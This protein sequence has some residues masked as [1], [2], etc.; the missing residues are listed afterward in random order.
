[1][2]LQH[3]KLDLQSAMEYLMTYGWALLIIAVVLAAMFQLGIFNP[4]QF[5]GQECILP[6][7][8]SCINSYLFTNGMLSINILQSTTSPINVTGYNC[9]IATLQNMAIIPIKPVNQIYL[10]VGA[11]TTLTMNC[12]SAAAI[13]ANTLVSGSLFTG[14]LGVNYTD[15]L[16]GFPHTAYG[17]IAIQVT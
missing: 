6:A 5:A 15:T 14:N 17:K 9:S 16:T 12:F 3:K 10:P 13:I 11:N 2:A 8:L 4:G 7:G 1:M